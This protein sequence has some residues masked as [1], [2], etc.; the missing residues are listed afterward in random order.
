[1]S[2]AI[3]EGVIKRRNDKG[4]AGEVAFRLKRMNIFHCHIFL[5]KIEKENKRFEKC[6][7]PNTITNY[8]SAPAFYI[9]FYV[10]N[11]QP[12]G[13]RENHFSAKDSEE[14]YFRKYTNHREQYCFKF[15]C[16]CCIV[17]NLLLKG[18]L[19]SVFPPLHPG[20]ERFLKQKMF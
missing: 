9:V 17:I 12:T 11:A 13:F 19:G 5:P 15:I 6:H 18:G 3:D 16:S 10:K 20:A 7:Q 8:L 2:S 4:G 14:I 1:M